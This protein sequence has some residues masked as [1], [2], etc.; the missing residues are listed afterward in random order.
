VYSLP[1][2]F[3]LILSTQN[4]GIDAKTVSMP[5]IFTEI[6]TKARFSLIYTLCGLPKDDREALFTFLKSTA[7]GYRNS[8]KNFVRTV[9]QESGV[10]Q[11]D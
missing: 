2:W 1:K 9:L 3:N 7:W 6:L 4:M 5:C 10:W 11:P 8:K